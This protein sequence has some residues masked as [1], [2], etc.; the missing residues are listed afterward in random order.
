MNVLQSIT[1]FTIALITIPII[2]AINLIKMF[3]WAVLNIAFALAFIAATI[4]LS[5]ALRPLFDAWVQAI[6]WLAIGDAWHNWLASL[7]AK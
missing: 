6:P 4:Y 3:L 7:S 5:I 1:R 2:A